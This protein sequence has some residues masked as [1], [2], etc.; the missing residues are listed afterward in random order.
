[1]AIFK[2]VL[3]P[4]DFS[5]GASEV[6][7]YA[8]SIAEKDEAKI[9]VLHVIQEPVEMMDVYLPN[10]SY[11][12][13]HE[14]MKEASQKNMEKFCEENIKGKADFEIHIRSGAPFVEIINAA[15][16]LDDDVI[17]M[18]THGRSG[19]DHVLFGSTAEKV[20]RKS[21]VPVLTVRCKGI[22]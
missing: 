13:L 11:D 7:Q 22:V 8:L 5:E 9:D 15:K 4:I 1:M 12:G 21:P 10:F 2:K 19:I 16:E 14:E 18:G 17:V 3:F 20:V 6:L